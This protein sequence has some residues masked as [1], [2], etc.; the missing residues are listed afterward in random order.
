MRE[1]LVLGA[2][3][4]VILGGI[5]GSQSSGDQSENTIKGAVIGGVIAGFASYAI[6][7]ALEKRDASVRRETLMNLEHYDVMGFESLSERTER[8][9]RGKCFTT[10][11][12][13]GRV[14]SIPC[15]L[16]NV[17]GELK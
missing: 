16:V 12:V 15:D 9:Q 2:G 17:S 7:G 6:H 3:S 8:N 11:E 4:G 5:A 1:S 14:M 10:Q 13:D